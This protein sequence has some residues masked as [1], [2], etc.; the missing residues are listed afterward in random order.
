MAL[1]H[2]GWHTSLCLIS[3]Q[4]GGSE[5][6]TPVRSGGSLA[7]P[8]CCVQ[9]ADVGAQLCPP[10]PWLWEKNVMI[11]FPPAVFELVALFFCAKQFLCF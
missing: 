11:G 1:R 6:L 8:P 5:T 9:E 2:L 10:S 4:F 7:A 3:E